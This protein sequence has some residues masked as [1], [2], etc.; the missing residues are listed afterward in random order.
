MYDT[1]YAHQDKEDDSRLGIG[2]TALRLGDQSRPWLAAFAAA[3][4][5]SLAVAGAMAE[6]SPAFYAGLAGGAAH[7][8]W[9]VITVDLSSR[10]DCLRKF[11]SN[12]HFGA[13]ILAALVLGKL[14]AD[15]KREQSS[16]GDTLGDT[17]KSPTT[18]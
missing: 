8:A 14:F 5:G 18:C 10:A 1:I 9:Q 13:I 15:P 2:S 4:V 17:P 11:Q 3:S 12:I 6:L 7:L 16:V